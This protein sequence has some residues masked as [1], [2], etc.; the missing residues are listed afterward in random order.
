MDS[1]DQPVKRARWDP[2]ERTD[3]K[4]QRVPLDH[5][6]LTARVAHWDPPELLEMEEPKEPPDSL[7]LVVNPD[8]QA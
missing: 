6:D 4:D 8:T 3:Q 7:E 2:S 1:Q 5:K